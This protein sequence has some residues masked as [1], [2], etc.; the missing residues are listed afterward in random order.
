MR[1]KKIKE[2]I[3]VEQEVINEVVEK[4]IEDIEKEDEG[5]ISKS[6]PIVETSVVETSVVET[7]V[8]ELIVTWESEIR[9]QVMEFV[10]NMLA[11][12]KECNMGT[13]YIKSVKAQYEGHA[14]YDEGKAEGA[15]LRIVFS[16]VEPIDLS[17]VN[18][19]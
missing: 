17:K 11:V 15:E 2:A 12:A 1:T 7:P 6:T 9:K 13:R 3:T 19:V 16:F 4:T 10:D 5:V 14:E 8:A 18:L